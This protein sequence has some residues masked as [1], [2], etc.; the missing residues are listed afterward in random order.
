MKNKT[1]K[2]SQTKI[3][4]ASLFCVCI[5]GFSA[6][7]NPIKVKDSKETIVLESDNKAGIIS[8]VDNEFLES[9]AETNLNEIELGKLAENNGTFAELKELGLMMAKDHSKA[10]V[11]LQD[12]AEKKQITLPTTITET[13]AK[14]NK[15]LSAKPG[16]VFDAEFC[17]TL[18]EAHNEAI[19]KFEK[20]ANEATDADIKSW[21]MSMIPILQNHLDLTIACQK[22]CEKNN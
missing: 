15:K 19:G 5:I 9:A 21:A 8:N 6:C 17:K 18:I 16:K 11:A 13:D 10:M 12:L 4:I 3:Y 2:N 20:A 14:T 1:H 7:T 22:M